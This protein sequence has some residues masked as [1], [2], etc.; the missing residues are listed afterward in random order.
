MGTRDGSI[1]LD[2]P[3]QKRTF[4]LRVG[5]LRELQEKCGN[6]GPR[7][8][9]N[10]LL[11]GT[12]LVDDIIQPVRLGLIG[13]GM[14]QG[15]ALKI[16]NTHL[17]DGRLHEGIL[18]AYQIVMQA[19]TGPADEQLEAPPGKGQAGKP[20]GTTTPTSS[21]PSTE[22]LPTPSSGHPDRSIN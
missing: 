7:T 16:V 13:A 8:I 5:E 22:T 14:S 11:N 4:R 10:A 17:G 12:Y 2:W 18:V 19:I 15:D 3:D 1:E 9:A 21:A 20:E 6:R